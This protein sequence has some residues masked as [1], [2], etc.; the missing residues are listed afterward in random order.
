MVTASTSIRYVRRKG[1]AAE[2]RTGTS[3]V[4]G[5]AGEG[6]RCG[7]EKH[8]SKP[9]KGRLPGSTAEG[10]KGRG[11]WQ[12]GAGDCHAPQKATLEGDEGTAQKASR[13]KERALKGSGKGNCHQRKTWKGG[14]E[15]AEG[16]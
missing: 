5:K 7:G 15:S 6:L 3:K 16:A 14:G 13:G 4:R 8:G 9:E 12:G 10:R 11:N 2:G 1:G